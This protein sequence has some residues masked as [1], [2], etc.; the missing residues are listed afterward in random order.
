MQDPKAIP[1]AVKI[2]GTFFGAQLEMI[3]NHFNI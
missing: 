2:T 1:L 3:E